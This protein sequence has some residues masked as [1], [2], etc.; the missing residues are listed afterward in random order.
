MLH[1]KSDDRF[2]FEAVINEMLYY[3]Q[4]RII[5]S[6][7]FFLLSLN[8]VNILLWMWTVLFD[9]TFLS[10]SITICMTPNPLNW[11]LCLLKDTYVIAVV[12]FFPRGD[13]FL[14]YQLDVVYVG[15]QRVGK[16]E[17]RWGTSKRKEEEEDIH[18]GSHDSVCAK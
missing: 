10:R 4:Y 18:K 6:L 12:F 9:S 2:H 8:N 1:L 5:G 17:M 7:C 14:S 11:R 15:I 3:F 13:L 16:I